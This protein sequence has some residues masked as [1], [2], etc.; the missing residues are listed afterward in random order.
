MWHKGL[1][2]EQIDTFRNSF[3]AQNR[4]EVSC[5]D[6]MRA[7][8]EFRDDY[9][10]EFDAEEVMVEFD[11]PMNNHAS[12]VYADLLTAREQNCLQ[13]YVNELVDFI[14]EDGQFSQADHQETQEGLLQ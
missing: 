9:P 8:E 2:E 6:A 14:N 7:L 12:E 5:Y 1:M 4:L 3:L 13:E 10:G 11:E